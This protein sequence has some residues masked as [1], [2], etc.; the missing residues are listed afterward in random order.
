MDYPVI[1]TECTLAG[2]GGTV[3]FGTPWTEKTDTARTDPIEFWLQ[4]MYTADETDP[5]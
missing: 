2:G 5:D 1:E 3:Y 4:V